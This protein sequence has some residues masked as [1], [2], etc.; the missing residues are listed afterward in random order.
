MLLEASFVFEHVHA[1]HV[2][3]K[4]S[5]LPCICMAQDQKPRERLC[6][7]VMKALGLA[8]ACYQDLS[9]IR[10]TFVVRAKTK[11]TLLRRVW[12]LFDWV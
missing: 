10:D 3:L 8:E 9:E 5:C 12:F 6:K 1:E 4:R 11:Q 7:P 2:V